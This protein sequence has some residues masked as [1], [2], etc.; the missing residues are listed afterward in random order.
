MF[1]VD[2]Y[3]PFVSCVTQTHKVAGHELL[4]PLGSRLVF[5]AIEDS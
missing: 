4:V 1:R 5:E 3:G 2:G